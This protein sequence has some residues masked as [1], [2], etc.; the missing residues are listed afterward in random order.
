MMTVRRR[1][2]L[3]DEARWRGLFVGGILPYLNA[4]DRARASAAHPSVWGRWVAAAAPAGGDNDRLRG[5]RHMRPDELELTLE[6]LRGLHLP[7]SRPTEEYLR[8]MLSETPCLSPSVS[9]ETLADY[10]SR[11]YHRAVV[12]PKMNVGTLDTTRVIERLT[13]ARLSRFHSTGA[14][15]TS[16]AS[17]SSPARLGGAVC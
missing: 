2:P 15:A 17:S 11:L 13:Q 10:L 8:R 4:V 14:A 6:R 7:W 1:S 12:P 5:R 3:E 16:I 9:L